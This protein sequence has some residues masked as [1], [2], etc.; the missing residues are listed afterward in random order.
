MVERLQTSHEIRFAD[1][2]TDMQLLPSHIICTVVRMPNG[3][4]KHIISRMN[5]SG[6]QVAELE[7][8][9]KKMLER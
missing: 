2:T 3:M 9:Q 7:Y 8:N 6:F 1:N 4:K 5:N